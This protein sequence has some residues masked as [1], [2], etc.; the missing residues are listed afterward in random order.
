MSAV[1]RAADL[2]DGSVVRYEGQDWTAYPPATMCG[3]TIRWHCETGLAADRGM[4]TMLDD[5]AQ[6]LRVGDGTQER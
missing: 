3:Q 2:P 1:P 5:G 6:V 4:D